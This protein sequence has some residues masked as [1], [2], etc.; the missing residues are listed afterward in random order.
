MS[1][2]AVSRGRLTEIQSANGIHNYKVIRYDGIDYGQILLQ[3]VGFV[4]REWGG[5]ED[6][7]FGLSGFS[8]GAQFAHRFWYLH[9]DRV[10]SLAV[11]APGAV[12]LLDFDTPWPRGV[13]DE[14][15]QVERLK[16]TP[17]TIVVGDEDEDSEYSRIEVAHSLRDSLYD[18]GMELEEVTLVRGAGHEEWKLQ[19]TLERWFEGTMG[20]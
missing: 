6:G 8:G 14:N 10:A 12:T 5:I 17:I 18:A 19:S 20:L 7:R 3:M 15:V 2:T 11:A 1:T 13:Q 9:P 16:Q 4:T